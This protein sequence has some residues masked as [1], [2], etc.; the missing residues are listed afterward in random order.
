MTTMTLTAALDADL[1]SRTTC[2]DCGAKG[3]EA[4]NPDGDLMRDGSPIQVTDANDTEVLCGSKWSGAPVCEECEEQ[5]DRRHAVTSATTL[6]AL[7]GTV[8]RTEDEEAK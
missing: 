1:T 7:L 5:R 3:Y 4:A 6:D 8:E 2:A